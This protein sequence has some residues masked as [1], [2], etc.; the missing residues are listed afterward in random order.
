MTFREIAFGSPEYRAERLLRE[1]V[2]R[3]PLGLTLGED[4]VAADEDQMHFGLFAPGNALVACVVA[5]EISP[6]ES[7]LRQMAVSPARQR[8]GLGE[9]LMEGVE[10]ILKARGVERIVLNARTS[11]AG[12]YEKL[13]YRAVGR[14][15]VQLTLPHVKMS[16]KL[17]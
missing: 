7:R 5:V 4:D 1:E 3:K 6:T 9:R 15:F 11:A 2:L 16:K 13:G 17:R 8:T 12:F 10:R 14:E